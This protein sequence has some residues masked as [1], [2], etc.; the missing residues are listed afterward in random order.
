MDNKDIKSAI[1]QIEVPKVDVLNSIDKGIE[2]GSQTR[3]KFTSKK[4]LMVSTMTA[5]SISA[6]VLLSGFLNPSMNQVLASAPFIGRIYEEFGDKL[7]IELA[8]DD[9]VTEL[10]EEI[11]QNGV[12]VKLKNA[13][14]DGDIVSIIG[15][16]SGDVGKGELHLDV[17]FQNYKENTDLWLNNKSTAI[18]NS[19]DG[20]DFQW[21][22]KYPYKE[23]EED[24]T[25][26]IS[27]HN[28]NGTKGNWNFNVPIKQEINKTLMVNQSKVYQNDRIQIKI[29]EINVA[30]ETANMIFE[31][32]SNYKNDRIDIYKAEDENGN[33]IFNYTNNTE[34][35]TSIEEGK[36]HNIYRKNINKI[37]KYI[38][39]ITFYPSVSISE[40]PVQKLLNT[41]S[42]VLESTRSDLGI[43]VNNV[44]KDGN[45]LI[46]DYN[47]KGL[48]DNLSKHK[49]DIVVLNLS[50]SFE[51]I[52]KD[53]INDI[54]P[55]N[56]FPPKEHSISRNNVE[57]IDKETYHF[58]SVFKLDGKEKIENFSLQDIILQFNF[59]SYI[60]TKKLEPFTVDLLE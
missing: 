52:D 33:E 3:T 18:K 4:K 56:P 8:K 50:Y 10:D 30:T 39:L 14:F 1:D 28:I 47:F 37:D 7:G 31:T 54:D 42:F 55:E 11:T 5:A 24:F 45:K 41:S 15:N 26:P 36:Y 48:K 44:T 51:L 49:F 53:F 58:Q 38:K 16:V 17:N 13:Y 60:E 29:D 25:L 59:D 20:Y 22:L 46:V 57:L 35:S 40:P 9:L 32:A 27:I 43:K 34:L 23:I 12:T 21:K 19:E 2:Q 6:I